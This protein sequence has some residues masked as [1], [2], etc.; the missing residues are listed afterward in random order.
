LGR[1]VIPA[2]HAVLVGPRPGF[3]PIGHELVEV[4]VAVVKPIVALE[5]IRLAVDAA[6]I[7]IR[8]RRPRPRRPLSI[9]LVAAGT[10]ITV[11]RLQLATP[12]PCAVDLWV[13]IRIRGRTSTLGM[14]VIELILT[15]RLL[16]V[17]TFV[18]AGAAVLIRIHLGLAAGIDDSIAILEAIA[19]ARPENALAIDTSKLL[20]LTRAWTN[21]ATR[22]AVVRVGSEIDV[23]EELR[24]RARGHSR[25]TLVRWAVLRELTRCR[26]GRRVRRFDECGGRA[27]VAYE[28]VVGDRAAAG[29]GEKPTANGDREPAA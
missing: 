20:E 12:I 10:A 18:S 29:D 13:A 15:G 17:R 21:N 8:R 5:A 2:L 24:R 26:F 11:A 9:G 1:A 6:V 3:T 4:V 14:V 16:R 22:T 28:D 23:T 27:E 25:R 7:G 19:T